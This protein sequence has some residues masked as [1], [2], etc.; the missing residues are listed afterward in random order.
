VVALQ[1]IQDD[2]GPT[3]DGTVTAVATLDALV[4]AIV[5]HGGPR[6]EWLALDP[7]N[8]QEGGQPGGNIRVA[9]LVDPGRAR[10][11]RRG[12][13]GRRT[14]E[15]EPGPH[16]AASPARLDDPAFAADP[17]RGFFAARRPLV[18]ELEVE[19]RSLFFVVVHLSSKGGDDPLLG[20]HQ[21]PRRSSEAQRREQAVAVRTLVDRLLAADPSARVVIL[22]DFNE[23]QDRPPMR[24]L[25][26]GGLVNLTW[27]L[28]ENERYS[29]LFRGSGECIDHV[30]VS[31]SLAP[32]SRVDVVH[33][34]AEQ[35][36]AERASDHDPVVV[37]LA[38]GPDPR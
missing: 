23:R 22:G 14:V 32:G 35:P 10:I 28:P 36:S 5:S 19:G 15:V 24:A 7:E 21:P 17:G 12:S 2:S 25:E 29:Y 31:P 26:A 18:A 33:V 1:E 9:L 34:D 13:G 38:L 16:L 30:V 20:L 8:D 3:D 6:Y 27:R 11:V 37:S 4:E